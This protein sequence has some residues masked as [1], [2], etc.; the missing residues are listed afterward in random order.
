MG[1]VTEP[2]VTVLPTEE[3][4]TMPQ[5]AEEMTATLAGPPEV[6]PAKELAKSIKK[7]EMPVRS[8]KAPKMMKTAMNLAQTWIGVAITP[9]VP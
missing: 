7:L 1:I 6:L 2:V 5:R 8:R 4:E 3:P 9:A